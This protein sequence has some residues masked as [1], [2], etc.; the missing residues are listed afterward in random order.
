MHQ[1]YRLTMPV[2]ILICRILGSAMSEY[3]VILPSLLYHG[4]AAVVQ[5][6][7]KADELF[8]VESIV[9]EDHRAHRPK[10]AFGCSKADLFFQPLNFPGIKFKNSVILSLHSCFKSEENK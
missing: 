7:G 1:T 5:V 2:L 6:E 8:T 3:V 9:G 4:D 10:R